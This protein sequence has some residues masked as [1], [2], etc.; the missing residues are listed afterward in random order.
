MEKLTIDIHEVANLLVINER[1]A[2]ELMEN[3][4]AT[5]VQKKPFRVMR[6][7]F[8]DHLGISRKE[9]GTVGN[10]KKQVANM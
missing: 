6:N 4:N 1:K 10:R 7:Q 3:S 9:G 5:V 2:K 8:F